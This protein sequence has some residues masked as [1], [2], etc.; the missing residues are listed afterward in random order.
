MCAF[1]ERARVDSLVVKSRVVED[2]RLGKSKVHAREY[3]KCMT[4]IY[5]LDANS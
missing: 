5:W 3:K 4:A 2:T 1:G